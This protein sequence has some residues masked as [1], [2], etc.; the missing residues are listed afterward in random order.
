MVRLQRIAKGVLTAPWIQHSRWLVRGARGAGRI[1]WGGV[2]IN[3]RRARV[4][5]RC[6]ALAF[7]AETQLTVKPACTLRRCRRA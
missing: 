4:N 6:R 2:V 3:E 7:I 1:D 5:G